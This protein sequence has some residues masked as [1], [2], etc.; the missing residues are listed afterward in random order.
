MLILYGIVALILSSY[1]RSFRKRKKA[2]P[3][4]INLSAERYG[5]LPELELP[6]AYLYIVKDSANEKQHLI[7]TTTSLQE[8]LQ[9]LH[10]QETGDL[11]YVIIQQTVDA[12]ARADALRQKYAGRRSKRASTKDWFD[13]NDSH[14]SDIYRGGD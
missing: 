7:G 2:A 10:K 6:A 5:N 8:T 12:F 9:Q 11:S 3:N 13:L 14:L 4:I 1:A